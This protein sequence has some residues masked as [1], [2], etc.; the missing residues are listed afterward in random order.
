MAGRQLKYSAVGRIQGFENQTADNGQHQKID[1][2]KRAVGTRID[3]VDF[4]PLFG[5]ER[6]RPHQTIGH[7]FRDLPGP[8][9]LRK[10]CILNGFENQDTEGCKGDN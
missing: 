9:G 8:I 5:H 10:K 6:Y 4:D 7:H 2:R 1:C 3:N